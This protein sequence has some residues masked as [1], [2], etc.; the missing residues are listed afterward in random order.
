MSCF[1]VGRKVWGEIWGEKVA[2]D[3]NFGWWWWWM[4]FE[5]VFKWYN[6]IG[7]IGIDYYG[8][9]IWREDGEIIKIRE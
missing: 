1:V 3:C 4:N 5:F 8:E 6:E 9:D 7:L 2:Y